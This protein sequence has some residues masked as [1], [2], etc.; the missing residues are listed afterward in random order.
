[1][2]QHGLLGC[3]H[4]ARRKAIFAQDA[5]EQ[6]SHPGAG[7]IAVRPVDR[8]VLPQAHQQFVGDNTQVVVVHRL[9]GRFVLGRSLPTRVS[10]GEHLAGDN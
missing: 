3:V 1:L 2:L 8:N 9:N 4:Q 5:L 10:M 7:R 6:H